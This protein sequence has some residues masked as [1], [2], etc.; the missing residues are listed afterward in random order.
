[1]AFCLFFTIDLCSP[2]PFK[3]SR[4]E[5]SIDVAEHRSV[6]KNGGVKRIIQLF[7]KIDLYSAT[8]FKRSWQE[9][10]IDVT[11]HGSILKNEGVKR[12]SVIF[13][14]RPVFSHIIQ[15]VSARAFH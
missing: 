15:E 12:I 11:E 5:R 2:T 3:R 9:L 13:H 10:S 1:M 7:S 14:D 8:S 6:L 4:R